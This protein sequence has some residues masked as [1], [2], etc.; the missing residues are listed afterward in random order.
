MTPPNAGIDIAEIGRLAAS[1]RKR[2]KAVK[3]RLG[4]KEQSWYPYDTLQVFSVLEKL[5]TAERRDF[6]QLA[7]GRPVLDVGCGDGDLSFFLE[8]LGCTVHAIDYAPTN[9]NQMR[10][11]TALRAALNSSVEVFSLDLDELTALPHK[12]YGLTICLGLLYHLKN[13]Y[14]LLERL[15]RITH[16]CLLSTRVS[17]FAP[18]HKTDLHNLPVAYLLDEREANSDPTN[19]WVFSE[20][21]LVRILARTG[22]QICDYLTQ[23]RTDDSDPSDDRRDQRAFCLLKGPLFDGSWSVALLRGWHAMEAG[24]YRW[25]ER[26]FSVRLETPRPVPCVSLSLDFF[27]PKEHLARLGPVTLHVKLNGHALPPQTFAR[28]G[29]QRYSQRLPEGV[30]PGAV[31]ELE[32]TLDKVATPLPTDRRELGLVVSFARPGYATE[33]VNLPVELA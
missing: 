32:F 33:D 11:V 5:L 15:A 12:G 30:V 9:N 29:E 28:P 7:G 31:A 22:W 20:A 10:G 3:R 24:D 6:L 1:F 16:Y 13:P 26:Q 23:G 18:D 2:L 25:T 4:S 8:S 19:F 21:G 14:A 17:R 27:L